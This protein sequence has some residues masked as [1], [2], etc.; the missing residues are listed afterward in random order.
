MRIIL[1]LIMLIFLSS[2]VYVATGENTLIGTVA[3]TILIASSYILIASPIIL[4]LRVI[5]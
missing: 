3:E 2:K 5:L 1:T 4:L